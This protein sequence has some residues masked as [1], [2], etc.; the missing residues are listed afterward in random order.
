[1]FGII[2]IGLYAANRWT[3]KIE[4]SKSDILEYLKNKIQI[5]AF[6][7]LPL[8]GSKHDLATPCG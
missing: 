2:I 4:Y 6:L 3:L 7:F 1:M 5:V 8:V